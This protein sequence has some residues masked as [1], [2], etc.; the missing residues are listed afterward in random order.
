MI[1]ERGWITDVYGVGNLDWD[2]PKKIIEVMKHRG[3]D[4]G[5]VGIVG[6]KMILPAGC[7]EQFQDRL[8][9]V[10]FVDADR[11]MDRIRAIKSPLEIKQI[12]ELWKDAVDAMERFVEVLEPGKTERELSAAPVELLQARGVRQYLVFLN[13]IPGDDIVDLEGVVKYHMEICGESGHWNEITV[14]PTYEP[15][16]SEQEMKLMETELRAYDEILKAATPGT[17]LNELAEVFERVLREDGWDITEENKELEHL[18]FHG[19]GLDWLEFPGWTPATPEL[20]D[21]KL[22]AGMYLCYHPYRLVEQDVGRTGINDG[23]II[24]EDGGERI[25][26]DWDLN[27]RFMD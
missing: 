24:T 19:G 5:K 15:H 18:D 22:E 10:E 20:H 16:P 17:T 7:Y 14:Q 13:G 11:M 2:L 6:K 12:K 25:Y 9:N 8:P 27:Y 4:D 26:P 3:L 21:T 23:M 1:A